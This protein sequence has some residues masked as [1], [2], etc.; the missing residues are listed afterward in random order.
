VHSSLPANSGSTS[1]SITSPK[2][3]LAF[4]PWAET[5]FYV[6]LGRSFHSNDA[7]GTTLKVDPQTGD[8]ATPVTPLVRALGQEAGVR[9]AAVP[10]WQWTLSLWRLDLDSELVFSGDAGITEPSRPSRREGVEWANTVQITPWA[11]LGLDLAWSKARFTTFDPVGDRIPGAVEGVGSLSLDLHPAKGW[12]TTFGLRCFGARPLIEDNSVRSKASLLAQAKVSWEPNPRWRFN[13]EGFNL[14]N[15]KAADI[16]YYYRS[17]LSGEPTA[18]L[19]DIHF[20]PIEPR[21]FRLSATWR[22]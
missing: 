5:E 9:S 16:D 15:R 13:L 1:A 8:P 7:R 20:H 22:F 14:A 12:Q 3:S 4:G 17:R 18:G 11:S 10:R 21:N 2:L 6:A 19:D